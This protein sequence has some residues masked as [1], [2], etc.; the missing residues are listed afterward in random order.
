MTKEQDILNAKAS[1]ESL[2]DK[3]LATLAISTA[4]DVV[5]TERTIQGIQLITG[6]KILVPPQIRPELLGC[7]AQVARTYLLSLLVFQKSVAKTFSDELIRREALK[8]KRTPKPT[9]H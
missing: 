4:V 7:E 1:L 9:E 8:P 3:S 6:G 2:P 5:S